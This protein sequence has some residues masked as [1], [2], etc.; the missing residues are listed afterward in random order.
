M[1]DLTT[2]ANVKEW[3]GM[4]NITASDALISRLISACSAYMQTAMSRDIAVATYNEKRNGMGQDSMMLKETPIVTVNSLTIDGAAIP[5]QTGL[6]TGGYLYDDQM[7]YLAGYRFNWGRQNVIVNYVGGY[8]T[9]PP[10][11]E[12]AC[13]DIIGDWFKYRER[14]GKTSEGIEGQSITFVNQSIPARAMGVILA[15]K[16]VSPVY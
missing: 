1:A 11:I 4:N 6:V 5:P 7:V 2:L 8:A 14:I 15:Y 3:L 10:D 9:T 13:I 16:R 12:Q